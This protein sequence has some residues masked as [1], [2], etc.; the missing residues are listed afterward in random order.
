MILLRHCFEQLQHCSG[1]TTL[2]CAK[3][4]R[5]ESSRVTSPL[6]N[7]NLAVLRHINREKA[8]LLV[9]V[10]EKCLC[11]SFLFDP[12]SPNSDPQ[13]ISSSNNTTWSNRWGMRINEMITKDEQYL[14]SCKQYICVESS[15][16]SLKRLDQGVSRGSVLGPLLYLVYT[17]SIGKILM[18]M[19]P[20]L[21]NICL[22]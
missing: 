14:T 16:F 19:T 7:T 13:P 4:H 21:P 12:L 22:V 5:C 3:N 10:T 20:K 18:R 1:I 15:K 11:L 17:S 9:G 8:S 6:S 2:C